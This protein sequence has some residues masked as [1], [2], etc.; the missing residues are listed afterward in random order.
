MRRDVL[1]SSL[2][3]LVAHSF[4][5]GLSILVIGRLR[6]VGSSVWGQPGL[7][8]KTHPPPPQKKKKQNKIKIPPQ[9]EKS[10]RIWSVWLKKIIINQAWYVVHASIC[11]AIWLWVLGQTAWAMRES[12]KG[13][14]YNI[15]C[16]RIW[17]M[18]MVLYPKSICST[19]FG[20]EFYPSI[21][22]KC[23]TMR[24]G[25]VSA[26]KVLLVQACEPEFEYPAAM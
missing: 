24:W 5:S 18:Y 12:I 13:G 2:S 6:Q 22:G 9:Q 16:S 10:S 23:V 1:S 25:D 21:S 19:V 3:R 17:N 15:V 7:H 11:E 20:H 26:G 4:E 14:H 8:N